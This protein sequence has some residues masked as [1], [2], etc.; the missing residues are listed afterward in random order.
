M[1]I[2]FSGITSLTIPEGVVTKI[3]RNADNA[4]IWEQPSSYPSLG[5]LEVGASVYM[6]VNKEPK[7]FLVVHQGL[8]SSAYDQSCNGTWL[9]SKECLGRHLISGYNNDYADTDLHRYLNNISDFLGFFDNA[10]QNIIKEVKVPYTAGTGKTGSVADGSAG[11]STKIFLPS[12]TELGFSITGSNQNNV[13]GAV[14]D[15]F[16]GCSATGKDSKRVAYY[17]GSENAYTW[18]SRSPIVDSDI[19]LFSIEST[20]SYYIAHYT[21]SVYFRPALILPSETIIDGTNIWEGSAVQTCTVTIQYKPMYGGDMTIEYQSIAGE[22]SYVWDVSSG[23]STEQ[24]YIIECVA[25]S[26]VNLSYKHFDGYDPVVTGS[27]ELA[28]S[29][30]TGSSYKHT[31][32]VTGDCTI[33]CEGMFV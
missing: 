15:Y 14:L 19:Y 27:A 20:G 1:S 12:M 28:T 11:L 2:D 7:E 24:T 23:D 30:N 13:E 3:I 8:P 5:R 33:S 21:E 17:N 22:T 9:L 10:I 32:Y 16:N 31:V 6:N 26:N 4:V 29:E 18:V 25:G